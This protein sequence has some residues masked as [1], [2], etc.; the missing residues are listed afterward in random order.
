MYGHN[1]SCVCVSVWCHWNTLTKHFAWQYFQITFLSVQPHTQSS[2]ALLLQTN[3]LSSLCTFVLWRTHT[4]FH[5]QNSNY[6]VQDCNDVICL[7]V[8]REE[9][10][11]S[12]WYVFHCFPVNNFRNKQKRSLKTESDPF[13]MVS[14]WSVRWVEF[15]DHSED[16]SSFL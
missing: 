2:K 4:S 13:L 14:A 8:H 11:P 16:C 7:C 10:R 1:I 6:S 15:Q 3:K 5:L 9:T 12:E